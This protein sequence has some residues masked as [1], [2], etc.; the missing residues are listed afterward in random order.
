MA[1]MHVHRLDTWGFLKLGAPFWGSPILRITIFGGSYWDHP[2]LGDS[3]LKP[4]KPKDTACRTECLSCRLFACGPRKLRISW[5]MQETL[6]AFQLESFKVSGSRRGASANN[7][8]CH[9]VSC[10]LLCQ[11][12]GNGPKS[13]DQE[14]RRVSGN[15]L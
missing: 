6:K 10:P 5:H 8:A 7:I 11:R 14:L 13:E 1:P 4:Q 12:S 3:H 2:V 15:D 9:P